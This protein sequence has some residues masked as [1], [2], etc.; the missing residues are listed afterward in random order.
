[1]TFGVFSYRQTH[2]MGPVW[3]LFD[4]RGVNTNRKVCVGGG[5]T[6]CHS[7]LPSPP[8]MS[9]KKEKKRNES[10]ALDVISPFNGHLV[11]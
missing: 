10:H 4:S 5:E 9:Q 6:F 8:E 2:I 1:M 11:K 3:P 7:S